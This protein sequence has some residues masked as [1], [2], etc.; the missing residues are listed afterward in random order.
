MMKIWI[1][2]SWV[3]DKIVSGEG[4]WE[5]VK[6]TVD[7]W[8]AGNWL[9][10]RE[11]G[12]DMNHDYD[13]YELELPEPKT[14]SDIKKEIKMHEDAIQKLYEEADKIWAKPD[15]SKCAYCDSPCIPTFSDCTGFTE[16]S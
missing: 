8:E 13:E 10:S 6:A 5:N 1:L 11:G 15:C 4:H 3:R 16:K 9:E 14:I 7:E 12:P 2:K